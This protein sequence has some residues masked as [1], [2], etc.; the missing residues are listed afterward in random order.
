M[1][2]LPSF[3]QK[4]EA[5]VKKFDKKLIP[6]VFIPILSGAILLYLVIKEDFAKL[7]DVRGFSLKADIFVLVLVGMFFGAALT[8]LAW[9]LFSDNER[10]ES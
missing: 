1:L 7:H 9:F 2:S 3:P 6:A 8:I 10:P 4:K 5:A